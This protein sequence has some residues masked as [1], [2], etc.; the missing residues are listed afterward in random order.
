MSYRR[1]FTIGRRETRNFYLT[2]VLGSWR[3]GIAGFGAVGALAALLYMPELPLPLRGLLLLAGAAAG[4]GLSTL[5]LAVSTCLRV[6][7]QLRRS[8]RERYVQ[9]TEIDG[10][11]VRVTVGKDR[12]RLGFDRLVRVRE[13]RRAFYLFIAEHQAWILP[14]AQMEDR[15][16]ECRAV[17]EIFCKVVERSRLRLRK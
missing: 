1:N 10:F 13:T 5:F 12:A 11:G 16:A 4:M 17:R 14:K 2:L 8:G 3:K 6:R 7:A 9:E 15:E